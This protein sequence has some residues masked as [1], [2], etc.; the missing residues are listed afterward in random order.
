M[1]TQGQEFDVP[2]T[3]IV[4][5]WGTLTSGGVSPDILNYVEVP[6]VTDEGK[7]FLIFISIKLCFLLS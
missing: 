2:G 1:P 3:A 7:F 4:S 6:L 5:G